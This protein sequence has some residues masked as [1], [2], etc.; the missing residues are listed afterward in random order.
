MGIGLL[1]RCIVTYYLSYAYCI[2]VRY[3]TF[4]VTEGLLREQYDHWLL[5]LRSVFTLSDEELDPLTKLSF[6][7]FFDFISEEIAFEELAVLR[8]ILRG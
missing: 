3:L 6:D 8:L 5:R 1:L 2:G 4:Q 7:S